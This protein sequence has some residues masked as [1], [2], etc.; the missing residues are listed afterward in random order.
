MKRLLFVEVQGKSG[1]YVFHFNGDPKYVAEWLADGLNV[2]VIEH[3]VPIWVVEMRLQ[4]LWCAVQQGWR[5]L[6]LW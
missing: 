1:N 3:T 5:F 2:G 4:R 6:R